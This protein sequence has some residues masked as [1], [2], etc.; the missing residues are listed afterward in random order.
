MFLA[1]LIVLL[2]PSTTVHTQAGDFSL[3]LCPSDKCYALQPSKKNKAY[4]SN[5][6]D[7]IN[8]QGFADI[9]ITEVSA[10]TNCN[11]KSVRVSPGITRQQ[12]AKA[13]VHE[14]VHVGMTC[15]SRDINK[16]ER[17][18]QAVSDLFENNAVAAFIQ[19]SK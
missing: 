9:E 7:P 5:I 18:A 2:F 15:D 4:R 12:Q 19:S 10:F 3:K 14:F 1:A 13:I 16:E 17:I 8:G 6:F 11:D